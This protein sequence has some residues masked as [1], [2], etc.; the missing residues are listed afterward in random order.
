MRTLI[1]EFSRDHESETARPPDYEDRSSSKGNR[2]SV[3]DDLPRGRQSDDCHG[4]RRQLVRAHEERRPSSTQAPCPLFISSVGWSAPHQA[5]QIGM[6][7]LINGSATGARVREG[8]AREGLSRHIA[9][10]RD[11]RIPPLFHPNNCKE[12]SNE[13]PHA[14]KSRRS[15]CHRIRYWC[16]CTEPGSRFAASAGARFTTARP[17]RSQCS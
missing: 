13:S 15:L 2:P 4:Q 3:S 7:A 1:G 14:D 6:V 8:H 16:R 12:I 5:S 17:A 11:R 9:C 10:N